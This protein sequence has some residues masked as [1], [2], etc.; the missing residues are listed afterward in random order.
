[1]GV[2]YRYEDIDITNVA[3]DASQRIKD[4]AGRSTS[5]VITPSLTWDS[6]DNQL[7]PSRGFYNLLSVDFAGGP[8]G[9]ENKF[10][11]AV[12]ET[13]WYYP[14]VSDVGPVLARAPWIC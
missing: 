4:L 3:D 7:N 13:N 2:G 11:K 14:L 5:S 12:G 9:A 10:Y 1:M 8:L 6:R